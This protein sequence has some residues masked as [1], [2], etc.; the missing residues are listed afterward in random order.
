MRHEPLV[1]RLADPLVGEADRER[2]PVDLRR[3]PAD[4]GG[5]HRG[6]KPAAEE[7]TH[8]HVGLQAIDDRLLEQVLQPL[9]V[10]GL[11]TA[12]ISSPTRG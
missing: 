8:G 5:D 6:V 1:L 2:M 11:R 3:Y 10:V 4:H 12:G 9:S 7:K